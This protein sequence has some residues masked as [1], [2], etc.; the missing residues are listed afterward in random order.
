M[1][2]PHELERDEWKDLLEPKWS[3]VQSQLRVELQ[4]ASEESGELEPP[5]P[6][7]EARL[8][9]LDELA[10]PVCEPKPEPQVLEA[11]ELPVPS[12]ME[13]EWFERKDLSKDEGPKVAQQ[14]LLEP[15]LTV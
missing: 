5:P 12:P 14:L 8:E 1:E 13:Q 4:L 2:L 15:E 7:R 9:L 3:D 10:E 11:Q 6:E